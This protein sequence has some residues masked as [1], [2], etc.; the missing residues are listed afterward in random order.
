M[1]GHPFRGGVWDLSVR[2][3]EGGGAVWPR[4]GDNLFCFR[5]FFWDYFAGRID[6]RNLKSVSEKNQSENSLFLI[7]KNYF[8]SSI[9]LKYSQL[10]KKNQGNHN[11]IFVIFVGFLLP[12]KKVLESWQVKKDDARALAQKPPDIRVKVESLGTLL[13]SQGASPW[14][15]G[16][17]FADKKKPRPA[18]LNN[19]FSPHTRQ[20][21]KPKLFIHN[22]EHEKILRKSCWCENSLVRFS[23]SWFFFVR[24]G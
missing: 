19:P 13:K 4:S 20:K 1:D 7:L 15:G 21:K 9:F 22:M 10:I 24:R 23:L 2:F 5:L 17:T 14:Y 8:Y 18:P 3:C 16:G 11:Q 12:T 6:K